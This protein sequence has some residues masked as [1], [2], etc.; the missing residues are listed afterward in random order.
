MIEAMANEPN[1][2]APAV[3]GRPGLRLREFVHV[4]LRVGGAVKNK[5]NQRQRFAE[6]EWGVGFD[7][8]PFYFCGLAL[9]GALNFWLPDF[10]DQVTG[11]HRWEKT[12]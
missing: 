3:G 9:G 5:R 10:D 2:G 6:A 1:D 4:R 11:V 12:S 8:F 7:K